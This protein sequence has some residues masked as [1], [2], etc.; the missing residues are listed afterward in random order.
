[1]YTH[2]VSAE[3]EEFVGHV[4]VEPVAVES[5]IRVAYRGSCDGVTTVGEVEEDDVSRTG[6]GGV[7]TGDRSKLGHEVVESLGVV[8]S[9]RGCRVS[10]SHHHRGER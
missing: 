4:G 5:V 7:D 1:M 9:C 6:A 10:P 3:V 2:A 8:G